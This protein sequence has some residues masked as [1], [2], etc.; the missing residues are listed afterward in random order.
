MKS[1]WWR[2]PLFRLAHL[3][4]DIIL[5]ILVYIIVYLLRFEGEIPRVELQAFWLGLS[6][7]PPTRLV[8]NA[9]MGLYSHL[10][11][12]VGLRELFSIFKAVVL[13][14]LVFGLLTY[15]IRIEG[16]PRS[17][18]VFEGAFYFLAIGGIRYSR[19]FSQEVMFFKK[20][21]KDLRT[22][23]IGAGDAG[24]MVAAEM[25]KHREHGFIPVGFIDDDPTKL[26]ARIHG[27][28]V[29]GTLADMD[30]IVKT[31]EIDGA[32]IAMPSVSR[33]VIRKIVQQCI[34]LGIRLEI[35]PTTY[36]ILSGEV[37]INQLRRLQIQDLLG[38]EPI[39]L[40]DSE[41][42]L[43]LKHKRI[44]VTGAGGSIGSELCRQI[45]QYKPA[46]LHLVG[47]GENSLYTLEKELQAQANCFSTSVL[48]IRHAS[49][50]S[51]L[52]H[53][54][55]PEIIFHAAAH[56]HVPLMENNVMEAFLNNVL[57]S[58]TLLTAAQAVG[59]N[60]FV[61]I[62]TDKSTH[63]ISIMGLSKYFAELAVH[64]VA[65]KVKRGVY[66]VVRFG[67]VIGSRGSVIPLFQQQIE[68]GGPVWV[69]DPAMTRYFMTIPEAVQ[70]V[71]QATVLGREHGVFTLDMG[72]PVNILELAQNMIRLS[73][74]QAGDIPIRFSG[75]RQGERLHETLVWQDEALT[76]TRSG[77]IL[78][79]APNQQRMEEH[80]ALLEG[81]L[82]LLQ[83]QQEGAFMD[84]FKRQI[85]PAFPELFWHQSHH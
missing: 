50:M 71:L 70:L 80:M 79:A 61:L 68:Q 51:N 56:K 83:Q 64:L 39:V 23:V 49:Q 52:F 75:I 13:G 18:L 32:V 82:P 22:L 54:Q 74:Y 65:R 14:S 28:P 77:S 1:A 58:Y 62:S 8:C 24:S 60:E 9:V 40:D 37:K 25:L 33:S 10:W 16:F 20:G 11:K 43:F 3:A 78:E 81:V 45:L 85:A 84:Y 76:P 46:H 12:Y 26:K 73:G 21:Q 2:F 63:P 4:I 27:L 42:Q 59:V 6:L 55:H 69:T 38:R 36:Q 44:L 34:P 31:Q 15:M 7:L 72:E 29:F 5:C 47:H 19:R 66:S 48:D 41:L 53:Q 35:V 17:I 67:N 57:G 30:D